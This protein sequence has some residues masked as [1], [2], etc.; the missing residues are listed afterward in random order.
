MAVR[1]NKHTN[2]EQ[3][4]YGDFSGGLNLSVPAEA[5]PKNEMQVAKNF[6]FDQSTGAP[7][8]RSGLILMATLPGNIRNLAPVAGANSLLVRCNDN[9]VYKLSEYTL[10]GE[11]GTV[12]GNGELSY[13]PWGD[14]DELVLA[15]GGKLSLFDGSTVST[16]SESLD[17][18]D[19]VFVKAGR[20]ACLNKDSDDISYSGVG[21]ITNWQFASVGETDIWTDADALSLTVGYKDGCR[22]VCVAPLTSDLMVFKCPQ[23]QPGMGRIYRV[24][25]NYP[26]W[27][28]ADYSTGSSVCNHASTVTTTNDL[29]FLTAEGVASLGTVA[30]YGDI[31]MQWAGAKVNPRISKEMDVANCRMWKMATASQVWVR[32]KASETVWVYNYGIGSGAWTT[33]KFPGVVA[34]ACCVGDSRYIAIGTQV[35]R[36]DDTSGT[37]NG[38]V[39]SGQIKMQGIRKLGMTLIKQAYIAYDSMADSIAKLKIEGHEISLPLGGQLNDVAVEDDDIASQDEDPLLSSTS[40]SVRARMNIRVWDATAE[41][42]VARGPFKLNAIG[43]EVAEV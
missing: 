39:F 6:E 34:D 15:A 4:Y 7:K 16:V 24:T 42:E 1:S 41:L 43:L 5:L 19:F 2:S 35:F 25:G 28:V 37:D 32:T 12:N 38:Q 33:F 20:V 11:L 10:S 26:D 21:D 13:A 9:K 27:E 36:M 8:L 31:K 14:D 18:N 17:K 40:A 3:V 23:D 22:M 29:L 30:A